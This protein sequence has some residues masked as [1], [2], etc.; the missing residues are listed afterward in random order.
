V[1]GEVDVNTPNKFQSIRAQRVATQ[2]ETDVEQ[3]AI[4]TNWLE[5]TT[6]ED[7]LQAQ[8]EDN[9][10]KL[11]VYEVTVRLR[12]YICLGGH[13]EV[14]LHPWLYLTISYIKYH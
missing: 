11:V 9:I 1:E 5:G 6:K 2:P 4:S 7:L 8:Q 10:L 12:F 3:N 13:T 14:I